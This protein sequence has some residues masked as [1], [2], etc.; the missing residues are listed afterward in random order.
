[1][2]RTKRV[3]L[4]TI[5]MT[6]GGLGIALRDE[7]WHLVKEM[8][9]SLLRIGWLLLMLLVELSRCGGCALD[10]WWQQRH[11]AASRTKRAGSPVNWPG[12]REAVD[13]THR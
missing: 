3:K 1:M 8:S 7:G 11:Q 12:E 10:K 13:G 6:L 5:P 9:R 4:N 2:A